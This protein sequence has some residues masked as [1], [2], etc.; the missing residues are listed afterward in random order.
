VKRGVLALVALVAACV[1]T[2]PERD[3][4]GGISVT[5]LPS[6]ATAGVPFQTNDGWT[7]TIEKTALRAQASAASQA[8]GGYGGGAG[9]PHVIDPRYQCELR[10]TGL[11]PGPAAV[12]VMLQTFDPKWGEEVDDTD[13]CAVDPV[14]VR[15]F[16][17]Y[18]DDIVV[19]PEV[20]AGTDYQYEPAP[21]FYVKAKAVKDGRVLSF[22]W[23]LAIATTA[24]DLGSWD[25]NGMWR[26]SGSLLDD[27]VTV[28]PNQ[29]VPARFEVHFESFFAGGIDPLAA[30]D[31]NGD[32][33]VTPDELRQ[34]KLT[35]RTY[36][37]YSSSSSSSSGYTDDDD[38]SY[39]SSG[40]TVTECHTLMDQL[41]LQGATIL[42]K[43]ATNSPGASPK[44][45][46]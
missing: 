38:D 27:V 18:A 20:L 7:V 16:K 33:V 45:A 11:A 10:A 42:A 36:V 43:R 30:A 2:E 8:L 13:V 21:S 3:P 24:P 32:G 35:C 39:S 4:R 15:R 14:T 28:L 6:E 44:S 22:D 12:Y 19:T 41:L 40:E 5:F 25:D 17:T 31:T 34:V 23:A 37:D 1:P 26:P 46:K 9:R 29:G